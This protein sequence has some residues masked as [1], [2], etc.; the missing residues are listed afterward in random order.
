MPI[1]E[2]IEEN[3]YDMVKKVEMLGV[4][5]LVHELRVGAIEPHY[6]ANPE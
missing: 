3:F 4:V 6:K 2:V 1:T 5:D